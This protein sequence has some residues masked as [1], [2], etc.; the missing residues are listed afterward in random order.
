MFKIHTILCCFLLTFTVILNGQCFDSS[1][2]DPNGFCTLEYNPVCV[3]CDGQPLEFSN[4]CIAYISGYNFSDQTP[5]TCGTPPCDLTITSNFNCLGDG[6]YEL[7]VEFVGAG[8]YTIDDGNG[9]L[10]PN[11]T[12]GTYNIGP[13]SESYYEV[14]ITSDIDP[15]CSQTVSGII[16]CIIEPPICDLGINVIEECVD[17]ASSNL[18]L[19]IEGS[20]IYTIDDG[21]GNLIANA[22]AGEYVLGPYPDGF[23]Y[24]IVVISETDPDCFQNLVGLIVGCTTCDLYTTAVI[25]CVDEDTYEVEVE[26]SGTGN[27]I[28]DGDGGL[29]LVTAG[30]YTLGPFSS[31]ESFYE[32]YITGETAGCEEFFFGEF[33]NCE[34]VV[35]TQLSLRVLLEGPYD[36][37]GLMKTGLATSNLLTAHP[38]NEAPYNYSGPAID[39]SNI[40]SNAVDFIL[41]EARETPDAPPAAQQVGILL[42]NGDIVLPSGELPSLDLNADKTYQL[43]I[44]HHN[45]LDIVGV[46]E[47]SPIGLISYP[48]LTDADAL[49]PQQLKE[50][51]TEVFAMFAGDFNR[52]GII[53][54]TD[55]DDWAVNPAIVNQY[56]SVD[57]NLDGV[58]QVTDYDVWFDNKAK[59]GF[60]QNQD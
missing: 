6:S 3:Y 1:I 30:T 58:T 34:P 31:N 57:A 23:A 36:G 40:P 55:Y 53:Q 16:D 21:A 9:N 54:I 28:I 60:A 24:E 12:E 2:Y 56:Q 47:I 49:G 29:L 15:N 46:D 35:N 38:Y 37:N 11:I 20:G 10:I 7:I 18:L 22:S 4:P 26:I 25:N 44:R 50:I 32:I 51:E 59:V 5:G 45:H 17:G 19:E 48:F 27:F 41:I 52:D 39:Y 33:P 42:D 14:S 43:W 13:Y 8:S